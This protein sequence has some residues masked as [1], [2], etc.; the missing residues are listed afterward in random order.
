MALFLR[1]TCW[2]RFNVSSVFLHGLSFS[3]KPF[4]Q[5]LYIVILYG[6]SFV[7][8]F[9]ITPLFDNVTVSER[10]IQIHRLFRITPLF[11][12]V[13]VSERLIQIHRLF[14]I[15]PLFDNVTVS[16][17]LIQIHRNVS[18][19][20][21]PQKRKGFLNSYF[22]QFCHCYRKSSCRLTDV[23]MTHI[24]CAYFEKVFL[25]FRSSHVC[26]IL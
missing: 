20:L 26:C 5:L 12:N 21:L 18:K 10:L 17:R 9:R 24:T 8:L 1:F 6:V 7:I 25:N 22:S 15:T 16:E 14:R 23:R 19:A 13:T 2:F 4:I 11:D 3:V